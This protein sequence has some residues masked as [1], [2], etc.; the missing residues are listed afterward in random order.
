MSDVVLSVVIP[1]LNEEASLRAVVRDHIALCD[2]LGVETEMLILDDGSTDGTSVVI[3]ELVASD[4]RIRGLT[5]ARNVGIGAS[6]LELYSAAAGSWIYFTAAD[7]Q[8]PAEALRRMWLARGDHCLVV[9]WRRHRRDPRRR[10][11]MQ[12]AYAAAARLVYGIR[13]RDID[14]VKLYRADALRRAWPRTT[15]T[16]SEAEIL[17]RLGRQACRITEVEIPHLARLVGTPKGG[18]WRIVS[19]ALWDFARFALLYGAERRRKR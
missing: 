16:F 14:S 7:G 3:S 11:L 4:P 2:E 9:G 10:L 18:S 15:S 1:A 5:H 17:I 8:I 12:R 6:L 19:R 13:V